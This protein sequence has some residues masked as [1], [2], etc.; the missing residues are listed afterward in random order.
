MKNKDTAMNLITNIIA[1]ITVMLLNFILTPIITDKL[2]LEVY[3]YVGIINNIISFFVVITYILNSMVGRFYTLSLKQS[4]TEANE[5]ISTSLFTCLFIAA[6]LLPI[7]VMCTL[8]LDK[9]IVID[10]RYIE[11]VKLAFFCSCIVFVL[12]IINS[13]MTTG[14]YAQNKLYIT[15]IYTIIIGI[16][17]TTIVYLIFKFAIPHVWYIA[18]GNIIQYIIVLIIAIIVFKKLIPSVS[19][20][21][22]LF[23]IEKAKELLSAG[24]FNALIMMGNV[25]MTQIDLLVG[26]RFLNAAIVGAYAV[27]LTFSS[28][29]RSIGSAFSNAFSPTTLHVYA[30]KGV[31]GIRDYSNKVVS[32]LAVLIGWPAMGIACL[33]CA[34]VNI[35][36]NR[37]L[38]DLYY[39]FVILML[40]MGAN[41][42]CTQLYVVQQAMNKLTIPAIASIV[43]GVINLLLA[44]YLVAYTNLGIIGIALASSISF[45][46]RNFLFQPL[47]T[48]YITDQPWYIFFKGLL[49]PICAQIIVYFIW[50]YYGSMLQIKTLMNF[51]VAS[52]LLSIVYFA[53]SFFT[54]SK[55]EKLFV[56]NKGRGLFNG[57]K[58]L[59][60]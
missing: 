58:K 38:S 27:V 3:S 55:D 25:L 40:P 36:L 42:A 31:T 20:S 6:A 16:V 48:S 8:F 59:W 50:L 44:I 1:M 26:N 34:F 60:N 43:S 47:Y 2:G 10:T 30:E 9:L 13:V 45:S 17:R 5:Y 51:I 24:T 18:L 46:I 49:R 12:S 33:G 41:L 14:A 39:V 11:D 32:F 21:I 53:I 23:K 4:N 19:F 28:T 57:E 15:N 7:M 35:W 56:I 29:M 22:K 54:L 37:D 52:I